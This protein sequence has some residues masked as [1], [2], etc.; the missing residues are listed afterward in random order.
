MGCRVTVATDSTLDT[1]LWGNNALL[2]SQNQTKV[3]DHVISGHVTNFYDVKQVLASCVR[4]GSLMDCFMALLFQ[5]RP[6]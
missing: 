4:Y 6:Q 5:R 2:L 3:H 1:E